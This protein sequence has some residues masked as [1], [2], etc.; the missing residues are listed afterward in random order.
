[1][2]DQADQYRRDIFAEALKTGGLTKV[3]AGSAAETQQVVVV[4]A[5]TKTE[6]GRGFLEGLVSNRALPLEVRR[7]IREA[8]AEEPTVSI[9]LPAKA[10]LP[11]ADWAQRS[12]ADAVRRTLRRGDVVPV[13]VMAG[14]GVMTVSAAVVEASDK[15]QVDALIDAS[16]GPVD[17]FAVGPDDGNA[18]EQARKRRDDRRRR[19]DLN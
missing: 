8:L 15:A 5:D 2:D 18:A 9:G 19:H 14:G 3:V 1:M 10:F 13:V 12:V 17:V 11:L 4:V 6:P 16:E 7:E